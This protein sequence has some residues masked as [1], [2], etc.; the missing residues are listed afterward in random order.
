M[1][2]FIDKLLVM[3]DGCWEWT[4]VKL[5]GGYGK[6]GAGGTGGKT[7]LAHRAAYELFIGPIP[8]GK[9]IDH[10]CRKRDCVNPGHMEPVTCRENLLRGET[11]AAQNAAKTH[12]IR[13]HPFD[14]AN[15]YRHPSGSRRCNT[16][17]RADD[18]RRRA[19]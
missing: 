10:L 12:C 6:I 16:C 15:T 11:L 9:E 2:R 13:G 17:R 7:L 4:G 18:R 19:K 14:E 5:R 1:D 3:P 8:D